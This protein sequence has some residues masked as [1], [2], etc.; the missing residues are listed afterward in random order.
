MSTISLTLD[1]ARSLAKNAFLAAGANAENARATAVALVAAEAD[2]QRGHGLAR[3][4]SYAAQLLAGKVNGGAVL[5][6]AQPKPAVCVIDADHGFAYPAINLAIEQLSAM[7]PREGIALAGIRHS[8]HFGQAGAHAEKLAQK[9][10]VAFV[11]GNSP[12]AIAFWGSSAPAMGTNPIAF[13]APVAEGAP[14]VIDLAVSVAARGKIIAAEKAGEKIPPTWAMDADGNPTTDPAE[15]LE[16]S[17]MPM[18]GGKGAALALMIEVLAAAITG[19]HFGF[20]ASSLFSDDGPAPNLGQLI[21]AIDPDTIGGPR[22]LERMSVLLAAIDAA[23][24]ARLPGETRLKK[25]EIATK[26]GIEISTSLFE[27]ISTPTKK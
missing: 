3:V 14:L 20:E 12:K 6:F 25:R 7:A 10:L 11:F 17:I 19:S 16:G 13:A 23:D 26:S 2:G 8:H 18:G 5:S 27:E 4:P 22:Y 15:A 21:I 9:G 1:E 24:G